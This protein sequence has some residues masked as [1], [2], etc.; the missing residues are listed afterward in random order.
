MSND[1]DN[2]AEAL[3][4]RRM[5]EYLAIVQE[6]GLIKPK[7]QTVIPACRCIKCGVEIPPGRSGRACRECRT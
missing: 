2:T 3:R 1:I 7:P 4:L 5:L 6:M